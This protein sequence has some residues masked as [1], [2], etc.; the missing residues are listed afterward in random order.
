MPSILASSDV[1]VCPSE[2]SSAQLVLLEAQAAGLPV[3][4]MSRGSARERV[5]GRSAVVCRAEADFIVET[6]AL[7][8]NDARRSAMGFAARTFAVRED[9]SSGLTSIYAEYRDAAAVSRTR[10]DLEPAFIPQGRRF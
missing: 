9:W 8:R 2:A 4:V 1:C 7:I 3:V 5:D 6:A 10:R